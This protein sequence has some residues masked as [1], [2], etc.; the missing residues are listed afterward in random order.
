MKLLMFFTHEFWLKPHE[1]VIPEVP[2]FYETITEKE[3]VIIFYHAEPGD[4]Q[5]RG[6]IISKFVKNVKWLAGKFQTRTVILHSFNHLGHEKAP[7]EVASSIIGEVR[8]KLENNGYKVLET[9][10]GYQNEWKMHV[11]G[12]SLAKVFKEI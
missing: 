5:K 1:K 11:A 9:P 10:F 7:P 6:S 4:D 8:K 2:D 12:N 3:S